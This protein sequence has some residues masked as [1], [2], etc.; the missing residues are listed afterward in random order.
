MDDQYQLFLLTRS[1]S[2]V[3]SLVW[4]LLSIKRFCA[5]SPL[6]PIALCDTSAGM[7]SFCWR[8][9]PLSCVVAPYGFPWQPV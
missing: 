9:S 6:F 4:F 2:V 8:V 3:G 5:R 7:T 1:Y